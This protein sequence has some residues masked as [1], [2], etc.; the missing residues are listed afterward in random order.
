MVA[1]FSDLPLGAAMQEKS[2][3]NDSSSEQAENQRVQFAGKISTNLLS[4]I[5][6]SA[7]LI[8]TASERPTN[9]SLNLV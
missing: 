5:T 3:L 7:Y 1:S 2:T 4:W 6:T 9:C 8:Q